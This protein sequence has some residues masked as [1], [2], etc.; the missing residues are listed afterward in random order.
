MND[1]YMN[2]LIPSNCEEIVGACCVVEKLN[3]VIPESDSVLKKKIDDD[4]TLMLFS[5]LRRIPPMVMSRIS[6]Q[7][8]EDANTRIHEMMTK[9]KKNPQGIQ[10]NSA[11]EKPVSYENMFLPYS[12]DY[13]P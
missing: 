1:L 3:I 10:N 6:K 8:M 4:N 9:A 5:P 11:L 7:H 13:F 2:H 12:N